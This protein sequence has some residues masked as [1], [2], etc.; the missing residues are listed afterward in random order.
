MTPR[1]CARRGRLLPAH[2][3]SHSSNG[4]SKVRCQCLVAS[5][6]LRRVRPWQLSICGHVERDVKQ[7]FEIVLQ[8]VKKTGKN[9]TMGSEETSARDALLEWICLHP[10]RHVPIDQYTAQL[11]ILHHVDVT[12]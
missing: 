10:I 2:L 12:V 1:S 6:F 5:M 4:A 3:R 11:R 8:R 9:E 7:R